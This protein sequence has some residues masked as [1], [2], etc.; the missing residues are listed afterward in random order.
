MFVYIW[1]NSIVN[2][3]RQQPYFKS[4][5][6]AKGKN[7]KKFLVSKTDFNKALSKLIFADIVYTGIKLISGMIKDFDGNFISV[8]DIWVDSDYIELYSHDK[9]DCKKIEKMFVGRWTE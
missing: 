6:V 8:F 2:K 3:E 1:Y 5:T 4:K 9:D 7:M